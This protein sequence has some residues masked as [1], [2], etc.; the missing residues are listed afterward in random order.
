M[1]TILCYGDSNTWGCKP[2]TSLAW[3]ERFSPNDRWPGILQR[4]L[5]S[6]F[7]VIEEGLGGRTTIWD[8][9]IEG[10]KNG[11]DY[12]IPCLNSHQPLD[13]VI[14]MLGTNDLK[15]RFGLS[16]FDIAASAG[17][18]VDLIQRNTTYPGD[19]K[20]PQVLL[21]APPPILEEGQM[22]EDF[23]ELFAGGAAKSRRFSHHFRRIADQYR[24]EFLDAA[25]IVQVS[26]MDGIHYDLPDHARL[27]VTLAEKVRRIFDLDEP[28]NSR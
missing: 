12:L 14:L 18:L 10:W 28:G 25:E 20:T 2:M 1:K 15:A 16:A 27:G 19:S 23:A 22:P 4:E 9:P 8:D 5:G 13:L 7:Q 21:I 11:R 26:R 17:V 6:N 3:V 24:C